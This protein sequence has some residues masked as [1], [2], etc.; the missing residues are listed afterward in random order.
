MAT[1]K[2]YFNSTTNLVTLKGVYYNGT[3][4]EGC[5]GIKLNGDI[6]VSF[7]TV[8]PELVW[9][10]YTNAY[11]DVWTSEYANETVQMSKITQENEFAITGARNLLYSRDELFNSAGVSENKLFNF[12]A[13][14]RLYVGNEGLAANWEAV[15]NYFHENTPDA[16]L[17]ITTNC[18]NLKK[19][20]TGLPLL[21]KRYENVDD[22]SRLNFASTGVVVDVRR[23]N[24]GISTSDW[25]LGLGDLSK[26]LHYTGDDYLTARIIAD[27]IDTFLG[28]AGRATV[29]G[30]DIIIEE[31]GT[32]D[33]DGI[34]NFLCNVYLDDYGPYRSAS[35]SILEPN[36]SFDVTASDYWKAD[37]AKMP[38][39]EICDL[40]Y[41]DGGHGCDFY[42]LTAWGNSQVDTSVGVELNGYTIQGEDNETVN[43]MYFDTS[44]L[45]GLKYPNILVKMGCIF[46][47]TMPDFL[48]GTEWI[49]TSGGYGYIF[50]DGC[51]YELGPKAAEPQLDA[52]QWANINN[53]GSVTWN[54]DQTYDNEY[55]SYDLVAPQD[56]ADTVF[57]WYAEAHP[58]LFPGS[59]TGDRIGNFYLKLK[60]RVYPAAAGY[61][62]QGN[63]VTLSVGDQSSRWYLNAYDPYNVGGYYPVKKT[64]K[65]AAG[66]MYETTVNYTA[67]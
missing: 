7:E 37:P 33:S 21:Y 51:P 48:E 32:W 23:S 11:N 61:N 22:E 56:I 18:V 5:K 41:Y 54:V 28:A 43:V 42:I 12:N 16:R 27:T 44:A 47:D 34:C 57:R 60:A 66:N 49:S 65:S 14:G 6:V 52:S 58:D 55:D 3:K 46:H 45:A 13:D 25:K 35:E 17:T 4:I 31:T 39:I 36:T 19:M 20:L 15:D 53:L 2:I 59:G 1:N 29:S 9:T 10:D 8:I 26:F 67:Q 30:D 24:P 63:A 62:D 50:P 64:T 40:D 38:S